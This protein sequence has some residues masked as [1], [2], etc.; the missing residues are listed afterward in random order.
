MVGYFAGSLAKGSINRKL[1]RALVRLAPPEL[2]MSEIAF[3]DHPLYSYDYDA[4]FPRAATDVKASIA[5]MDA[6][7]FVKRNTTARSPAA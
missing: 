7:L 5:A 1:E 6:V 3:G 4:A 2:E